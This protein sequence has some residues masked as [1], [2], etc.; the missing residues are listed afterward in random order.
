MAD[1]ELYPDIDLKLLGTDASAK[2][3]LT[4]DRTPTQ[5]VAEQPDTNLFASIFFRDTTIGAALKK[6]Q[7][8]EFDI[9]KNS[10][11]DFLQF[12]PERHMNNFDAY[13]LVTNEQE[14]YETMKTLD[15]EMINTQAVNASPIKSFF[16]NFAVQPLDPVNY[17]PGTVIF[18]NYK[19]L[20]LTAKAM[21]QAGSA[22]VVS[23]AAQETLIQSDQLSRELDESIFNTLAAGVFSSVVGGAVTAFGPGVSRMTTKVKDRARN[24][25]LDVFVDRAKKLSPE[26]TLGANDI[27]NMPEFV[28]KGM[29]TSLMNRMFKSQ[30]DTPKLVSAESYEH[31]YTLLKNESGIPNINAETNIKLDLGKAAKTLID[32]QDIFFEQAGVTRGW[33]AARK[34]NK[35]AL[36][37]PTGAILNFDNFDKEV[38]YTIFSGEPH[39]NPAVNK[40]AKLLFDNVFEK[41]K[42]AAITLGLLPPDVS[43]KNA[44]AYFT[45]QWN[46][47]KIKE[48]TAGFS[49][50][51]SDWFVKVN[52]TVR[53]IRDTDLI[54]GLNNEIALT[55]AEIKKSIAAANKESVKSLQ[56]QL[57]KQQEQ[58][59]TQ[60][61]ELASR[62]LSTDEVAGIFYTTGPR[63]GQLR[64]PINSST[65][66]AQ[67]TQT[68]DRILGRDNSRLKD[69]ILSQLDGKPKPLQDRSF[70]IP[71]RIA[72]EWQNQSASDVARSYTH[73]MVPVIRMTEFAQQNGFSDIKSWYDGRIAALTKEFNVKNE[74]LTGKAASDLDAAYKSE[75]QN[76]R[77]TF[78]LLLGIYG[79]GPNI[80]D[81]SAAKYYKAFLNWNYIRLL[82]F[83]TLSAIPDIGLHVFTHGPFATV[84][85]GLRPMLKQSFGLMQS[86]SK[87]DL[88]AMGHALNTVMGTRL[89]SL[90]GHE[91]LSTQPTFFGQAFNNMVET[92]GNLTLMNQW[93]DM[94]QVIAG[95]MS[96]NRTLKTIESIV[97]NGKTTKVD[98]ERLAKLGIAPDEYQTIYELWQAYGGKDGD[99]MYANWTNWEIKTS[100]QAQALQ[101]FQR[102]VAREID[103][104]V[105]IPGLGDKPL[106]AQSNLGKL[107]LQFK[108]FAFAAT[109]KIL[110]SGIQRRHDQNIYF[111]MVTMMALGAMSYVTTQALRGNDDIDLSFETLSKEAID[112]SGLLGIVAEGYNLAEKAGLGFGTNVSRYQSR[113]LWGAL[114]G[115]STGLVEDLLGTVNRIRKADG[116]NPLTTKDLEKVLR[117]APYQNLFYTYALSRKLIGNQG[118]KLGFEEAQDQKLKDIFK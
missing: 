12:V 87:D 81:N 38:A 45:V 1:K 6:P 115:P 49:A 113:G 59:N 14:A 104:V 16:Y 8:T 7:A 74:G 80:H 70:L 72:F 11:F 54:K 69:P 61:R 29:L 118:S 76:I 46:R 79:D 111:G 102:A 117:L 106:I 43:V 20:S 50:M 84:Y 67:V 112:R 110:F 24:E 88:N 85:H 116:D 23:T 96:I 105:I 32:Y 73:A 44:F 10:L 25:L 21:L 26:G 9:T 60:A 77:D 101:S 41:Y 42:E 30:F 95:T 63:K 62:S 17:I 3:A 93:N 75:K 18:N 34:A 40:G 37:D 89:K 90:A 39:A 57:K 66:D 53:G 82:G 56:E 52:D 2:P 99:T 27:A 19:R 98:R 58:L 94:Q 4:Y 15:E 48:N 5:S 28:Q 92:F 83:M 65:I 33:Q 78:E 64:K 13:A 100:A 36:D 107:L 47:Q 97:T 31:N 86:F 109:N 68:V 22:G 103:S 55:K 91:G 51:T 114:L 71:Q 35:K 108:S